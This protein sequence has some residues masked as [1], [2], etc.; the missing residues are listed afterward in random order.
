MPPLT[1]GGTDPDLHYS[2][3]RGSS[4]QESDRVFIC[5]CL[6]IEIDGRS[7]H[8]ERRT[9]KPRPNAK[10]VELCTEPKQ[11]QPAKGEPRRFSILPLSTL[12]FPLPYHRLNRCGRID[13]LPSIAICSIPASACATQS[14]GYSRGEPQR[15]AAPSP[16]RVS[17]SNTATH[18]LFSPPWRS[19]S[20]LFRAWSAGCA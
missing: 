15:V 4:D 8:G 18:D 11:S 13:L 16:A 19:C 1:H 5:M 6:C 14:S 17:N 10:K 12:S 20:G 9:E 7:E 2:G 3:E